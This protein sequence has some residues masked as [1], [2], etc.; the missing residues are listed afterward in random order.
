MILLCCNPDLSERAHLCLMLKAGCGLSVRE[1]AR[2][3]DMNEEAV[4][5]TM[6]RAKE[7]V[8]LEADTFRALD[9]Q[10]IATRFPVVEET[11]YALFTEGY[12]AS[13]GDLPLRRDVAAQAVHLC[14]VL[15]GSSFTPDR[16]R[17]D[18]HALTALMLLQLAR[19]DARVDRDGVPVRLQEQNRSEWNQSMIR[20]GLDA[21]AAATVSDTLSPYHVEA[22][23]AAE[24]STSP[25]F[26]RTNWARIL[27]LYDQLLTLKDSAAVRLNRIVALR[28]ARGPLVALEQLDSLAPPARLPRATAFLR[29]T[30]RADILDALGCTDEARQSWQ[31]ATAAAP[32]AADRAFVAR[33]AA[34]TPGDVPTQSPRASS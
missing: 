22:R 11:V 21:L 28:Y 34:K 30:V 29:H 31:A 16:A 26:E 24:H 7:K 17:G 14:D 33:R 10:R 32:T 6:T 4:K 5:K 25:S 19:F 23:I 20:A 13:S 8:A 15:L 1:I 2:L 9:Q 12:A 3:L 27:E 18:L